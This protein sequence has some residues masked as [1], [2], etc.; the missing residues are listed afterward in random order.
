MASSF[1]LDV[2]KWVEKAK[3]RSDV[4]VRKV[5]LELHTQIVMKSPV[6]N[7]SLWKQP[8]PGYV[9]GR[10]RNNWFPGVGTRSNSTTEQRDATGGQSVGRMQSLLPTIHAG[11][12]IFTTNNLAYS[13]RLE[14]G[15]STQAPVGMVRVAV[16]NYPGVI[17]Q[18]VAEAKGAKP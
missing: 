4:V 1:A 17:E 9:G 11:D 16:E 2:S 15:W 7:P 12:V 3:G 18:A 13:M 6:G 5:A 14:T 10:F 8:R